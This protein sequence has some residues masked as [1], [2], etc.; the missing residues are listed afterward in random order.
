MGREFQKVKEYKAK[1]EFPDAVA[2][3]ESEKL[4]MGERWGYFL[5]VT[6]FELRAKFKAPGKW[7]WK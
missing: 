3:G 4:S 5:N 6:Y 2:L 7:Q 1:L